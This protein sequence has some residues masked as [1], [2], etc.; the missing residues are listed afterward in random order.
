MKKSSCAHKLA[1]FDGVLC[2]DY[3]FLV[4]VKVKV[5]Q[6]LYRLIQA[7]RLPRGRDCHISTQSAQEGGKVVS[8]AHRPPLLFIWV[9]M[10]CDS[11]GD[12]ISA[13][14]GVYSWF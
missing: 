4:K 13:V 3:F 8:P 5:K 14:R 2:L 12:M 11:V 9:D 7:Q 1:H 10:M 6:S